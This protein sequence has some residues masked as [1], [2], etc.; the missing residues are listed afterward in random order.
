MVDQELL[1]RS[2]DWL[3]SRGR[4]TRRGQGCC[5]VDQELLVRS[6]DWLES[7]TF[8]RSCI[9]A[10]KGLPKKTRKN[11]D[12]TFIL[13][14]MLPIKHSLI[15]CRSRKNLEIPLAVNLQLW[16]ICGQKDNLKSYYESEQ[17]I[18]M[19]NNEV[20]KWTGMAQIL[21]AFCCTPR[22][23]LR[24]ALKTLKKQPRAAYFV[25]CQLYN[26]ISPLNKKHLHTK[27][28][29]SYLFLFLLQA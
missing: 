9:V 22:S 3:E 7:R 23:G 1:V 4:G 14:V 12:V 17:I 10:K 19:M 5:L 2:S 15:P 20:E 11:T 29:W 21:L 24:K 16:S 13:S 6:S 28:A 26:F 18:G 25:R 27:F 8:H